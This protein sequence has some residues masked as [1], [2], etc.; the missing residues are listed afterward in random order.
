M[1]NQLKCFLIALAFVLSGTALGQS[2]LPAC[3]EYGYFHN[4][5]GTRTYAAKPDS[6]SKAS[7]AFKELDREIEKAKKHPSGEEQAK[8]VVPVAPQITTYVGEFKDDVRDGNGVFT[9]YG[10][11]YEGNWKNDKKHGKGLLL[12]GDGHF[13]FFGNFKDDKRFGYGQLLLSNGDIYFGEFND[14]VA[15]KTRVFISNDIVTEWEDTG[16]SG[17]G[18]IFYGDGRVGLGN[19]K[20]GTPHG[21]FIEYAPDNKVVSSGIY[22]QGKLRDAIE[23]DS[24]IFTLVK[25]LPPCQAGNVNK[26]SNCVGSVF[27][28]NEVKQSS[29]VGEFQGGS[30]HGK[31]KYT[32]IKVVKPVTR[33]Y[34]GEFKNGQFH[35]LGV[36]SIDDG[37]FKVE[38]GE[39]KDG[40]LVR[41][42]NDDSPGKNVSE[43]H[44]ITFERY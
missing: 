6:V 43:S 5:F 19:W 16:I 4:C 22:F 32:E 18:I 31:G 13:V 20:T 9:E 17:Q 3:P 15:R 8:Q 2:K 39:W 37:V 35:G 23:I 12:L 29:Y 27:S 24:K 33:V 41:I 38:I 11:K 40:K 30:Y 14:G 10:M 7:E 42:F 34:R 25:V 1:T 28:S 21:L 44:S 36:L 26:W